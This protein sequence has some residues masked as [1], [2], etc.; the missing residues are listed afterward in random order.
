[1]VEIT[2]TPDPSRPHGGYARLSVPSDQLAE[3][4][5]S[6]VVFD[7]FSSRYLGED[8]FQGER[9]S[10]GPYPV[11]RSDGM[12]AVVVGPEIVNQLEDVATLDLEVG[13]VKSM[14]AWPDDVVPAMGAARLGGIVTGPSAEAT[15]TDSNLVGQMPDTTASAVD[16]DGAADNAAADGG[17]ETTDLSLEQD[18]PVGDGGSKWPLF[19]GA[20]VLL[21]AIAGGYWFLTQQ[22]GADPVAITDP[23]PVDPAPTD[24]PQVASGACSAEALEDLRTVSFTEAQATLMTCGADADVEAAFRVVEMAATSGDPQALLLFAKAYDGAVTEPV[25]ETDM[26]LTLGDVP[27]RAAEYYQR[28]LAGGASEALP[29]LEAVCRRLATSTDTIDLAAREEYCP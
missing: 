20:A 28:A 8:G 9:A 7:V 13:S 3:E 27:A 17:D 15:P 5:V 22:D 19:A 26:G 11:E 16:S 23:A 10:F 2:V 21:L 29:L 24:A 25:I 18:K 12:A 1:M 14:V 6:V 4:T